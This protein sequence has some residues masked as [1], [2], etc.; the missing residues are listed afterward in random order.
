M[1]TLA[2]YSNVNFY[3]V[4]ENKSK[5]SQVIQSFPVFKERFNHIT[6]IQ[7]GDLYSAEKNIKKL[8]YQIGL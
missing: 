5:F 3:V 4:S 8:R 2:D 6:T 1:S 7:I